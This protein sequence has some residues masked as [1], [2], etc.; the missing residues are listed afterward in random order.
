MLQLWFFFPPARYRTS[1]NVSFQN[2]GFYFL[3]FRWKFESLTWEGYVAESWPS[4]I[5][6]LIKLDRILSCIAADALK[7]RDILQFNMKFIN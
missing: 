4:W 6:L 7:Q 2:V 5:L 3:L 1:N